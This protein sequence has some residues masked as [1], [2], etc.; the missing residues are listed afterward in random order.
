MFSFFLRYGFLVFFSFFWIIF[1]GSIWI[2]AAYRRYQFIH[3]LMKRKD[4]HPKRTFVV[5]SSTI[6][7]SLAFAVR[8][9]SRRRRWRGSL[10]A[11]FLLAASSKLISTQTSSIVS[12]EPII[13]SLRVLKSKETQY[14]SVRSFGFAFFSWA[15]VFWCWFFFFLW[16]CCSSSSFC[17]L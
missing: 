3:S 5:I 6:L 1:G 17:T 15:F 7:P 8:R 10:A 4:Y 12:R 16:D 14:P 13:F 2:R 11:R 9:G